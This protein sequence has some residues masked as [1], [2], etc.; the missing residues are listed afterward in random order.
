MAAWLLAL[1]A[2]AGLSLNLV[3]QL[4]VGAREIALSGE[5]GEG[6]APEGAGAG[7]RPMLGAAAWLCA[8]LISAPALWAALSLAGSLLP[9]GFLERVLAFPFA[10]AAFRAWSAL[11]RRFLPC[12]LSGGGGAFGGDSGAALAGAAA[13]AMMSVAGGIAEALALSAGFAAG[14]LLAAAIAGEV[15]RRARAEAVPRWLRGAPLA[16]V[17]LGLLSLAFSSAAAVF[18]EALAR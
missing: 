11:F 1:A 3:L 10:F 17:A 16:L 15:K 8:F 4:G 7:P 6:A 13:F 14:A 12:A 5:E 18:F 9:L 2:F